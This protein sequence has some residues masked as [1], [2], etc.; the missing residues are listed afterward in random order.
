LWHHSLAVAGDITTQPKHG[1]RLGHEQSMYYLMSLTKH[2][3]YLQA[4]LTNIFA[5]INVIKKAHIQTQKLL[6]MASSLK[7]GLN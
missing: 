5:S 6:K 2:Y 1:S 7:L 4:Y 3:N